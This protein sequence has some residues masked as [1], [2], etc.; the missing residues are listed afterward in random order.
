MIN[1]CA[2]RNE[3][4]LLDK[5]C[6]APMDVCSAMGWVADYCIDKGMAR[7]VSKQE[8]LEAKGRAADYQ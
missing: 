6:G 3:M 4:V 2:C 7:R 1:V 8:F 5:G